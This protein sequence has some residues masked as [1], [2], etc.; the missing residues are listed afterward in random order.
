[1]KKMILTIATVFIAFIYS[2]GSAVTAGNSKQ[3]SFNVQSAD[4]MMYQVPEQ[5]TSFADGATISFRHKTDGFNFENDEF[6]YEMESAATGKVSHTFKLEFFAGTGGWFVK[7]P[8]ELFFEDHT[9]THKFVQ[10][11]CQLPK[12]KTELTLRLY[13]NGNLHSE[14]KLTYE[15]DGVHAKYKKLLAKFGNLAEEMAK[16]D[17]QRRLADEEYDN[18]EAEQERKRNEANY[19][20]V[21]IQSLNPSQTVY[22]VQ[23]HS[24]NL[25]KEVF[26]VQPRKTIALQLWRGSTYQIKVYNQGQSIDNA[27]SVIVV[28]QT[29]HGKTFTVK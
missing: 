29:K 2:T 8:N 5:K 22:I 16:A 17:E 14:G 12:G 20:T 15:S 7:D 4:G 21:N 9:V 11:L 24:G 13:V 25:K 1:M 26:E 6:T 28:D 3:L 27:R 10:K 18:A 23:I 19:Y